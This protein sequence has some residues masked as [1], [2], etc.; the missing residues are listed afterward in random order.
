MFLLSTSNIL[1]ILFH[2]SI[3]TFFF[4][5]YIRFSFIVFENVEKDTSHSWTVLIQKLET[6]C[7]ETITLE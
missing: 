1:I 7:E 3:S 4:Y 2:A 6:F 5:F